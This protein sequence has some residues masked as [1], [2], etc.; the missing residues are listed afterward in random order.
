MG[1]GASGDLPWGVFCLVLVAA[2]A[3]SA[4][5]IA[6]LRPYM[7]RYAL[8]RPN[9]RSS[10]REPTPQGG[11]IAVVAATLASVGTIPVASIALILGVE[12][13]E[14]VA[15]EEVDPLRP[16][17]RARRPLTRISAERF[18]LTPPKEV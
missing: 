1:D 9:A 18:P 6:L 8:A 15:V 11:G 2:M 12:A 10:H 7:V 4:G 16:V 3:V 13:L 14:G 5:L 17:D